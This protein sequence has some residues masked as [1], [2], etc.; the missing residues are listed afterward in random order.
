MALIDMFIISC[1]ELITFRKKTNISCPPI[2]SFLSI[3]FMMPY[4]IQAK[5]KRNLGFLSI[6][7]KIITCKNHLLF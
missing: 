1:S 7:I 4:Q 6:N 5:W 2:N 3:S